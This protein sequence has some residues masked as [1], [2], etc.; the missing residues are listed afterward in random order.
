[1]LFVP[2][3]RPDRYPRALASGADLVCVDLEDAV[4]PDRKD[5]ARRAVADLLDRGVWDG[6]RTVLRVNHPAGPDGARDLKELGTRLADPASGL[7]MVPKVSSPDDLDPVRAATGGRRNLVAMVETLLGLRSVEEV[8]HAD[9]VTAL[10]FG[11]VDLSSELGC[12]LEWDALLHARSR[13]VFAAALAGIDAI[14]V[15]WLDL[16]DGEGLA[17]E[18]DAV[19][20]LGFRGKAA[21]HPDQVSVVQSVFTP[22]AEQVARATRVVEGSEAHAGG[23]FLLD[24]RMVDRPV[25]EAARRTLVLA[26]AAERPGA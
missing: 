18:A 1:V 9:S 17:K 25:V 2:G 6:A 12:A 24:G 22:T 23:V 5:E 3:N 16:A 21:I 11:G 13:V 15:P 8:A 20:R 4:A 14:D 19:R 7:L 10:L 26:R